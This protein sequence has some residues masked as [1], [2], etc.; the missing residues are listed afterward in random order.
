MPVKNLE[1]IQALQFSDVDGANKSLLEFFKT[2]LPFEIETVLIRPLAVSLNSINGIITLKDN[3]KLFFKTHVESQG[4]INEYYNSAVLSDAG[5]KVLQPIHSVTEPGKQVLIYEFIDIPSLFDV[6]HEIEIGERKEFKDIV[7]IQRNAD[8]ELLEIYLQTLGYSTA[9]EQAEAPIH[10]LFYHRLAGERFASF[11]SGKEL[12]LPSSVINFEQLKQLS[13]NINGTVYEDTIE[14][15]IRKATLT[16][17]PGRG[18]IASVVGHG[19]AHNGNIFLDEEHR[20]LLYFDPAFAGRHSPILDL[21]KPLFHN[22]FANWMY[23]PETVANDLSIGFNIRD[24]TIVVRHDFA[25]SEIRREFFR[26]KLDTVLKPL[27]LELKSRGGLPPDWRSWLKLA[28]FCCPFLTMNLSDCE[29]FPPEITLLGLSM[30]VEMG[31]SGIL[32]NESIL[33]SGIAQVATVLGEGHAE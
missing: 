5:Y 16:L 29:K 19:D 18:D 25:P 12:S 6:L 23:F 10:Q 26:S 24:K 27:L 9:K 32:G 17:N 31:S 14:S 2:Y 30:S 4:I 7:A 8:A 20:Q 13:W 11:Y 3:R 33:D 22:V 28:L 15:L 1:E 21:A